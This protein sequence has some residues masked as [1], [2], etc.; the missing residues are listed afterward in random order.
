ML[1]CKEIKGTIQNPDVDEEINKFFD[2]CSDQTSILN[3][4]YT[5]TALPYKTTN[6]AVAYQTVSSCLIFYDNGE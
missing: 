4:S 3:I 5:T 6:N 1:R 2:S